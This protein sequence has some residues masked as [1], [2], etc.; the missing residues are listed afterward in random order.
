MFLVT[1]KDVTCCF[2]E[3]TIHILVSGVTV[4]SLLALFL[5]LPSWECGDEGFTHRI[6]SERPGT[7]KPL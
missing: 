5:R 1:F 6:T 3:T 7:E 2:P 4:L